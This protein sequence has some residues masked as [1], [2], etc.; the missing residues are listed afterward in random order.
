M[1]N[2]NV[3]FKKK[4]T[5]PELD[6]YKNFNKPILI[7]KA[8]KTYHRTLWEAILLN[9]KQDAIHIVKENNKNAGTIDIIKYV[10]SMWDSWR[11]KEIKKQYKECIRKSI[12]TDKRKKKEEIYV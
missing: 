4:L 7:Q 2:I 1:A 9:D 10:V 6:I 12:Y 11:L 3:C 5:V 8:F